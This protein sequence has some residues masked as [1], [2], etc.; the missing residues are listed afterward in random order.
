MLKKLCLLFVGVVFCTSCHNGDIAA[1]VKP[2]T[3]VIVGDSTVATYD[4]TNI[5]RGWGQFMQSKFKENVTVYNLARSG[6]SSK[7]Y[8]AEGLWSEALGKEPDYVFIQFG[9]NDCP[10]KGPQRETD[11]NTTYKDNLRKYIA[12]TRQNGGEPIIVTPTERRKFDAQEKLS[13]SLTAYAAAAREV[14]AEQKVFLVD[15]HA[16]SVNLFNSL[17]E[18]ATNY[19]NCSPDDRTHWSSEGATLWADKVVSQ[20]RSAK[21][22]YV[23]LVHSLR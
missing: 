6:R 18:E 2:I 13:E 22:P 11:P 15:L 21:G 16:E 4:E 14:A 9:H 23:P 1:Q 20:L 17:G 3:V 8:I 19:I 10:G 12:E 5:K 7:S